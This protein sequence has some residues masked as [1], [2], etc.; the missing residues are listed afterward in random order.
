MK[1]YIKK[2]QDTRLEEFI[3][4]SHEKI[5]KVTPYYYVKRRIL[6]KRDKVQD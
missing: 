1:N 3:E 5:M 4:A 6:L 2:R